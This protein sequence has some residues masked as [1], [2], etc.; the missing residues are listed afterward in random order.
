MKAE[1]QKP[2]NS[3][4][5]LVTSLNPLSKNSLKRRGKGKYSLE[6]IDQ[7]VFLSRTFNEWNS[8]E[9]I[10]I[11]RAKE[12]LFK[13]LDSMAFSSVAREKSLLKILLM[14]NIPELNSHLGSKRI[15]LDFS[16]IETPETNN[17]KRIYTLSEKT[18]RATLP[19]F[20][21]RESLFIRFLYNSACRVSE[22]LNVKLVNCKSQ[23]EQTI[24]QM[25]GKGKKGGFLR[26]SS[27][28]FQEIREEFSGEIFL[29]EN[30]SLRG[31]KKKGKQFSRQ[32]IFE[33]VSKFEKYTG[34]PF[35]PHKLRHSRATNL[36]QSGESL[37][38]VSELL[39]H[40]SKSTTT[41]FYDHTDI[42][43]SNLLKGEI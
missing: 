26:I 12:F 13:R 38:G 8:G 7:S 39:R 24:I 2:E 21:H 31:N 37:S 16:E 30:H 43:T 28:L 42:E 18:L 40:S 22:M 29:F 34:I 36:L 27:R 6:T 17:N 25:V 11:H 23:G 20:T 35:S 9:P 19:K 32:Y 10:T 3:S 1:I 4:R 14:E 15:D 5:E 33:I 41:K